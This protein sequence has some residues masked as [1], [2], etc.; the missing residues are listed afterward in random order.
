MKSTFLTQP[1]TCPCTFS[2]SL[3]CAVSFPSLPPHFSSLRQAST[4]DH[5]KCQKLSYAGDVNLR[6]QG[7]HTVPGMMAMGSPFPPSF[8]LPQA[9]SKESVYVVY[10]LGS[11]PMLLLPV[12]MVLAHHTQKRFCSLPARRNMED[13]ISA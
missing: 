1:P 9:R 11:N 3:I 2:A 6:F 12:W 5:E 10:D 4:W 8:L 13:D 7:R